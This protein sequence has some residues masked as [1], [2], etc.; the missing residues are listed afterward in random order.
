MTSK[1]FDVEQR[2]RQSAS[3]TGRN[4][5]LAVVPAGGGR[6]WSVGPAG[7]AVVDAVDEL[8]RGRECYARRAWMDTAGALAREAPPGLRTKQ[9][10]PRAR[11]LS[12]DRRSSRPER[13]PQ[14]RRLDPRRGDAVRHGE[15]ARRMGRTP[16]GAARGSLLASC[17]TGT[18]GGLR[19]QGGMR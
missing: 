17:Q 9:V 4:L 14:D 18:P 19:S 5:L 10:A 11:D 16:D 2:T 13:L 3:D 7:E 12:Q 6:R 8:E 15:R 1:Q